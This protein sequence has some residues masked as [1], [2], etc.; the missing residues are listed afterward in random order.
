MAGLIIGSIHADLNI[1]KLL[2]NC[3]IITNCAVCGEITTAYANHFAIFFRMCDNLTKGR[4]KCRC[5]GADA[6]IHSSAVRLAKRLTER[7]GQS[8]RTTNVYIY[9]LELIMSGLLNIFLLAFVSMLFMNGLIWFPFLLA[10]IPL[11]IT[12]G[13]YHA[14]SHFSCA[15][16]GT[17]AFLLSIAISSIDANWSITCIIISFVSLGLIM[18]LSPVQASNKPLRKEAISKNRNVS[19]WIALV[20]IAFAIVCYICSSPDFLLGFIKFYF[21]G[22]S[23]AAFS[24]VAVQIQNFM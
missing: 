12:A 15:A 9:G 4:D 6:M 24:M 22:V 17:L 20:N 8:G 19:I 10:F 21:L 16:V 23:A 5:K 11:R 14:N 2:F 1:M 7:Q 13:G 18:K 3:S